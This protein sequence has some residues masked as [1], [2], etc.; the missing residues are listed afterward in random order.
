MPRVSRSDELSISDRKSR[1]YLSTPPYGTLTECWFG[2]HLKHLPDGAIVLICNQAPSFVGR[3]VWAAST[4]LIMVELPAGEV[5]G[6]T[7]FDLLRCAGASAILAMDG[8]TPQLATLLAAARTAGGSAR[9]QL[10]PRL[11]CLGYT[12]ASRFELALELLVGSPSGWDTNDWAIAMGE[13]VRSLERRCAERWLVPTPRRWLELVRAIRAVQIMQSNTHEP[14]ESML[15]KAGF[16]NA[17]TGRDLVKKVCG[18]PPGRARDLI[19]W[20]WIINRW[21]QAFWGSRE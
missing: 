15:A 10:G 20:Y 11:R 12:V 6:C 14:V 9:G 19:G 5:I 13:S 2:N 21:C 17:R 1:L 3:V 4:A 16:Q 18:A 7:D 8:Q